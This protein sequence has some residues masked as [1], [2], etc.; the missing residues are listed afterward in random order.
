MKVLAVD[1]NA[2]ILNLTQMVAESLGH[3]FERASGGRQ[4]LQ[5]MR[6][7]TYDMVFL[8]LSMPDMTGLEVIDAL[9][10]EGIMNKQAVVLFTASYLSKEGME[11]ELMAKGL[12]SILR[13]PVDI[14]E[15]VGL[16]NKLEAEIA[17]R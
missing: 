16:C 3:E 1:D 5:N 12:F 7:K 6:D 15:M 4:G 11:S 2:D 10:K 9:N 8:D 14:E 13:K 17:K